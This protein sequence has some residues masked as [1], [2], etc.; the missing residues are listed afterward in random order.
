MYCVCRGVC[1]FVWV[2]V[3]V[4]VRTEQRHGE[5]TVVCEFRLRAASNIAR[6]RRHVCVCVLGVCA[7]CVCL[8]CVHRVCALC[9]CLVLCVVCK[10][11]FGLRFGELV[12]R[13]RSGTAGGGLQQ[14]FRKW[15]R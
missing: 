9:L 1:V 15:F 7:L 10:V 14:W 12:G 6:M 13:S 2:F 3:Y 5:S 8:E 4:M 11:S